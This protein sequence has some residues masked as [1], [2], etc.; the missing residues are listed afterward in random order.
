MV[1]DAMQ[2]TPEPTKDSM[3]TT[4]EQIKIALL[5]EYDHVGAVD[6][7]AWVVRYPEHRDEIIDFWLW[8]KGTPRVT[9]MEIGP[10]P[11]TDTD[12]AEKA[13]RDA[14]LA[15][16]L[17]RQW[18]E[19]PLD[20]GVG[21]LRDMAFALESIRV[22][23]RAK[24]GKAPVQFRKAVVW[25]WVVSLFQSQRSRVSRL[26]VQ[27]ATYLLDR[28]MNLGVFTEHEP[29]PL[30]PYDHKARYK[31]AEPIAVKKAWLKVRGTTLRAGDDL[32]EVRRFVGRYVR[33]Q[34]LAEKLVNYLA[35]LSDDELETLATVHWSARELI[36]AGH[37]VSVE[38]VRQA[39]AR[40]TE[41]R[42]KL[43]RPNFSVERVGTALQQLGDLRLVAL[44]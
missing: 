16:N 27:K 36:E 24:G 12:V 2:Y 10:F 3:D 21:A 30:G 14:C 44:R 42:T 1:A 31:D 43:G 4:I 18:L 41:W 35:R 26:A 5:S 15:V 40:T 19:A 32:S 28:A 13:L 20:P 7:G 34:E 33:S 11:A 29:K 22:K 17:G 25:T 39:L 37:A 38:G 9:E 8:V 23:P 6:L